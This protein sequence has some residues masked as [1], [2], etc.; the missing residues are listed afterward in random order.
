MSFQAE[1]PSDVPKPTW[2]LYEDPRQLAIEAAEASVLEAPEASPPAAYSGCEDHLGASPQAETL[3]AA[4][5]KH[6]PKDNLPEESMEFAGS[7]Q[8][9]P[10][11]TQ[12]Q[13]QNQHTSA[14]NLLGGSAEA[15]V[16]APHHSS[17]PG[18]SSEQ[19]HLHSSSHLVQDGSQNVGP[20][21][22]SL[23]SPNERNDGKRAR[24]AGAKQGT[25]QEKK[26]K[27]SKPSY[28]KASQNSGMLELLR[29]LDAN[30]AAEQ[31]SAGNDGT[32][33]E[34]LPA[35]SLEN[36][37]QN[38]T[39]D[40]GAESPNKSPVLVGTSTQRGNSV[41]VALTQQNTECIVLDDSPEPQLRTT[42]TTGALGSPVATACIA[43]DSAWEE[44]IHTPTTPNHQTT[45]HTKVSNQE[46]ANDGEHEGGSGDTTDLL[47]A[48][49]GS[50]GDES[51]DFFGV[52]MGSYDGFAQR[53]ARAQF[54]SQEASDGARVSTGVVC[55]VS[56]TYVSHSYAFRPTVEACTVPNRHEKLSL[57]SEFLGLVDAF[58]RF[59]VSCGPISSATVA[60]CCWHAD[61]EHEF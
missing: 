7:N 36:N 8:Y 43:G 37:N 3:P 55:D 24:E 6:I 14:R 29:S 46:G 32:D 5:L 15:A 17:Q 49:L 31:D 21:R 44:Q 33:S 9:S 51:P 16:P 50:A 39:R 25:S 12:S 11:L 23:P 4:P 18:A 26:S 41:P 1:T 19:P 42:V 56:F 53:P 48:N 59:N 22:D 30:G 2:A 61:Q 13:S 34:I 58:F 47:K 38:A 54:H 35:H 20:A 40:A 57:N 45:R 52:L 10:K 27:S 28:G 60:H